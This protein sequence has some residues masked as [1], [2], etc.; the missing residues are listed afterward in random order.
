MKTLCDTDSEEAMRRTVLLAAIA[1]VLLFGAVSSSVAQVK[2]V[3][4]HIDGYLCGN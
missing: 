3:E 4:M 1:V 2:Q